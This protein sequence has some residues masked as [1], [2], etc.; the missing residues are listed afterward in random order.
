MPEPL[1]E[2]EFLP[3]WYRRRVTRARRWGA[4]LRTGV[5]LAL[6]GV[7]AAALSPR[8]APAES[9][10]A[11]S[12]AVLPSLPSVEAPA[13]LLHGSPTP[14]GFAHGAEHALKALSQV[15]PPG[16]SVEQ[17]AFHS[18][19]GAMS[20]SLNCSAS[21]PG[22]GRALAHALRGLRLFND[23]RLQAG[24]GRGAL[25][26]RAAAPRPGHRIEFQVHATV[27]PEAR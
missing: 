8:P 22:A 23:V 15:L 7:G 6:A 13:P 18:D 4:A 19:R 11:L 25:G 21:E 3:Q 24:A 27:N 5:A 16:V 12:S 17:L 26:E 1:R 20:V 2:P 10:D 14:S 9:G